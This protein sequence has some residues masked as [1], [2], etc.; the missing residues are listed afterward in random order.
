MSLAHRSTK[1]PLFLL[2][3]SQTFTPN[4]V[5]S[6]FNFFIP[7][8][9]CQVVFPSLL[10]IIGEKIF[11]TKEFTFFIDILE[12]LINERTANPQ[13]FIWN[14]ILLMIFHF[15]DWFYFPKKYNDFV[16]A[17]TESI[18][19]YTK[20]VDGKSVPVWNKE[21]VDEIVIAQVIFRLAHDQERIACS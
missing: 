19:E 6:R 14:L 18:S 11:F 10:S 21:E 8:L 9:I 2:S 16:E 3:V 12:N 17:A 13:V 20:V 15:V 4:F 1:R 5:D 7:C